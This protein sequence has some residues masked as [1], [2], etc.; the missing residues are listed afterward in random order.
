MSKKPLTDLQAEAL[1]LMNEA[2][3]NGRHMARLIGT[4]HQ[5]YSNIKTGVKPITRTMARRIVKAFNQFSK[6]VTPRVNDEEVD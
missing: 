6:C 2:G 3:T 5:H 4:Q 1:R